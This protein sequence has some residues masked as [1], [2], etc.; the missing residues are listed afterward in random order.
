M[1]RKS[2][3]S[4]AKAIDPRSD[5]ALAP[6]V[7]DCRLLDIQLVDLRLRRFHHD[8][9]FGA[10]AV[11]PDVA[12][13]VHIE[14]R[15]P[16]K[17]TLPSWAYL[18][19]AKAMWTSQTTA[20]PEVAEAEILFRVAYDFGARETLPPAEAVAGLGDAL[21]LHHAWPYLRE[22]LQAAAAMLEMPS[23]TLPLQKFRRHADA[24]RDGD[25]AARDGG[26]A[27]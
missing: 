3:L 11:P 15:Y 8:V 7:Q 26:D 5:A 25:A 18:C 2:A 10:L 6:W 1:R 23:V 19:S 9:A 14:T 17:P 21:A 13:Q 20:K 22:R 16:L 4:A 12:V 27:D 24:V